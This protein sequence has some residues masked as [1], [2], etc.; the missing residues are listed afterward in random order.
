MTKNR[1]LQ[2]LTQLKN[3]QGFRK[4]FANTSWLMGERILRMVVALFVGVYVARYLGPAQF[5]LLSYANS[6]VGLFVALA[7]L[8]LDGIVVRELVKTPERRD[9]LLGTAFWLKIGGA[10]LMWFAIIA[11][12]PL[13]SNDVQTNSLIAIIAFAAIFQAFNVIDFNY[14]AEV[15]SKYVVHAQLVQ[16]VI[17]SVAKLILIFIQAPLLWF[18]WVYCLDALVLAV[19]LVVMYLQHSGKIWVWQWRWQVAKDL[20]RDSW[21]LILSGM[22]IM[23]YMRIDQ[24]MIKEMLG[25][26]EVGLYAAAVRLSE[27]WYF[28]PMAITA[29]IFPAIVNAKK[30]SEELYYQR[31]QKLYDLMVW[32]SVA[33]AIPTTFLAPWVIGLLYG[34]AYIGAAQVLSIHIWAGVFVFLGVASGKWFLSEN[35]QVLSFYRTLMGAIINVILNIILIKKYGIYG[36]ALAT[37]VA[38]MSAS[39]IFNLLHIKTRKTFW[40]ET[41]AFIL[42]KFWR[43]S[44]SIKY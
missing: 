25:A 29:S 35:L 14:Q 7:T 4:Y 3:H 26:E 17:S 13:T 18:A 22:V 2:K 11:A 38:Q 9:E 1:M 21:P 28:L 23:I 41:K 15:K 8:G 27:T 10:I 33:I 43:K 42:P 31:L 36:A 20:L 34:E 32:M 16:L 6:F 44:C 24:V 12:V 5:G 39:Y 37:L 19:G 40:M 30:Q